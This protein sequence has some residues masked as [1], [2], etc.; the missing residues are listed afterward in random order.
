MGMMGKKECV[1]EFILLFCY[2]VYFMDLFIVIFFMELLGLLDIL[3][4]YL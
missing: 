1:V 3:G 2:F 4:S